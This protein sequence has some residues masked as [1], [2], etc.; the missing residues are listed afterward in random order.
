MEENRMGQDMNQNQSQKQNQNQSRNQGQMKKANTIN[1]IDLDEVV[2]RLDTFAASDQG[3]LKVTVSEEVP[4]GEVD[5]K[6]HLGRC[7]VGSPW[8]KGTCM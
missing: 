7:D 8:A 6:Y 4:E 5:K 2:K 3:R 1:G